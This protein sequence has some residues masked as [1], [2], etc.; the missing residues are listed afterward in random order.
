[1][2][3]HDALIVGGGPAG[4]TCAARLYEAGLDVLVLDRA[5]FPR[6]KPFA[7]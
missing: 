3:S 4:S 2:A 5:A 7:G 1:M 6:E